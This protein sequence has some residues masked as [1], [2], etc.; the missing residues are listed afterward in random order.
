MILKDKLTLEAPLCLNE[1]LYT[2]TVLRV[3]CVVVVFNVTVRLSSG[4]LFAQVVITR[5]GRS[6]N[7]Q[8]EF[9]NYPLDIHW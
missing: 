3:V 9:G 7:T 5:F 8:N 6:F 1:V 2:Y 4:Q